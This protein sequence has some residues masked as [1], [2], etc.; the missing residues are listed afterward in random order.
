MTYNE[1]PE[2]LLS[3]LPESDRDKVIAGK[4]AIER[5]PENYREVNQ[6][7]N[8]TAKTPYREKIGWVY[9]KKVES[10]S[11]WPKVIVGVLIP[12][13]API[14]LDLFRLLTAEPAIE[15]EQKP[16]W[17]FQTDDELCHFLIEYDD[18][19]I[20]P[21]AFLA[22]KRKPPFELKCADGKIITDSTA[23]VWYIVE[24]VIREWRASDCDEGAQVFSTESAAK[25][26]LKKTIL[27]KHG[28]SKNDCD[29]IFKTK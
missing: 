23:T 29:E 11:N 20:S 15:P 4:W 22:S 28:I 2:E 26:H 6:W 27:E 16:A 3:K 19:G 24:G 21:T 8:K 25:L 10:L 17:V 1:K 9:S 13:F 7:L 14:T 5:T 12:D 18:S